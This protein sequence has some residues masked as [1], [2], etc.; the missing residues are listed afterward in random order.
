LPEHGRPLLAGLVGLGPGGQS[1]LRAL[2][3][4]GIELKWL[5][6]DDPQRLTRVGR[7]Q[8]ACARTGEIAHLL[9][10]GELDAVLIAAPGAQLELTSSVLGA[11]KHAF[12]DG[13]LELSAAALAGLER[14]GRRNGL[15]VS[16]GNTFLHSSPVRAIKDIVDGGGIGEL[17]FVSSSRV[18]GSGSAWALSEASQRHFAM[19]L[20]WLGERPQ[21]VR[22][23]DAEAEGSRRGEVSMLNLA[24]PSG[25]AA[26][27]E[28]D[29][30][31]G[32]PR[33]R[34]V[35]VG[36]ERMAVYDEGEEEGV[37]T[38]D[39]GVVHPG[40]EDVADYRISYRVGNVVP[41]GSS[42]LEPLERALEDFA[43]AVRGERD[44]IANS[45]LA[46]NAMRVVEAGAESLRREGA[47]VAVVA[48]RRL[49]RV[50]SKRWAAVR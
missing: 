3:K 31:E 49:R 20:H 12:L 42:R 13:P 7:Q 19:L 30:R 15:A 25:I 5:C 38:L 1:L 18:D 44:T 17:F 47:E 36:S 11:G 41:V 28:L 29:E 48:S 32:S 4:G 10:D 2:P 35:L 46:K 26:N 50:Q 22:A 43:G 6:D 27:V 37:S 40:D 39:H 21:T 24:F 16:C 34:T 33:G 45:R 9:G 14:L 23:V 8:P